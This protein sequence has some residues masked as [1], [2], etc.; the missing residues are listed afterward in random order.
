MNI[1]KILSKIVWETVV[2]KF[3]RNNSVQIGAY[4]YGTPKIITDNNKNSRITIGKFCSIA[5][6]VLITNDNHSYRRIAN[7]PL[8][9]RVGKIKEKKIKQRREM[10]YEQPKEAQVNIG[11]D[12][13]IGAGA[14]ILPGVTVGDGAIIGAGAIVTHDIPP[15]AIIIGVPA[16][17]LRYRFTPK[18]IQK[19]LKIAWWN[20]NIEKIRMNS[21]KFFGDVD[22]FIEEFAVA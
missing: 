5:N 11:N 16:K 6:D 9:S 2:S 3:A 22:K 15:Y 21:E 1:V 12:V 7:Y 20:W 19:L 13:W 8:E 17:I 10:I 4:T 18:Q 14:I